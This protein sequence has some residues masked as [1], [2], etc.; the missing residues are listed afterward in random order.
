MASFKKP[1]G[2][3]IEQ[4]ILL[5]DGKLNY[6]PANVTDI[7]SKETLILMSYNAFHRCSL[8]ALSYISELYV[9]AT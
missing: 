9:V 8:I 2:C 6:F 4:K 5:Y 7:I 1:T 3:F